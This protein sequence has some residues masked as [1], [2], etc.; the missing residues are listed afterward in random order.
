MQQ[1]PLWHSISWWTLSTLVIISLA[2]IL[3]LWQLGTLPPS[4]YWEEVA[5]GYDAYSVLKTGRDHHGAS[6]PLIAFES[7]G[8]WKPSGYFYALLPSLAIFDLT[9][10][11]VRLPSALAGIGI[12]LLFP[13]LVEMVLRRNLQQPEKL[14]A[15]GL[16]AVSPWLLVF[17]RG[18]WE[19]N[20]ATFLV[21]AGIL[22]WYR[23][24]TTKK[25]TFTTFGWAGLAVVLLTTSMY[26]YHA[27]RIIAPLWALGSTYWAWATWSPKSWQ[28]YL[29]LGI[30]SALVGLVL[31]SPIISN[32]NDK[33][34]TQ[35]FQE[36]SIFADQNPVLMSN[37]LRAEHGNAWW[38]RL[39][40]HR[41]WFIAKTIATKLAEHLTVDFLFVSGDANARHRSALYGQLLY[42]DLLLLLLGIYYLAKQK[43]SP[44]WLLG[45][46]WLAAT[47]PAA[48]TTA[49]PHALRTLPAA[50][51][52]LSL[53]TTG[54]FYVL[55][56][57]G[58]IKN[59]LITSISPLVVVALVLVY[60]GF[61][62]AWLHTYSK[63]Y[64][65][66]FA[67]DWQFGYQQMIETVTALSKNN[68]DLPITISR[69]QG[70]PAMYWWFY[71][72][73]DP[74][75]VQSLA[76][77]TPKDQ[78]EFLV[79]NN[80]QFTTT[81]ADFKPD[82]IV[83]LSEKE[84]QQLSDMRPDWTLHDTSLIRLPTHQTVWLIGILRHQ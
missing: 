23:A 79:F 39:V 83:A 71:T 8:D 84:W 62:F 80:I 29:G 66:L 51:V 78:G 9:V 18:A 59:K 6:W 75:A 15:Y 1:R 11:S 22:S 60:A 69:Q 63:I 20:L 82:T 53:A 65:V 70:R 47:I 55:S 77:I 58:T 34:V 64:P 38:A 21:L 35:R 54:G 24:L 52:W 72:K 4:P 28:K 68:P 76:P 31:L 25:V 44:I 74:I 43:N 32:L 57:L 67:Q 27:M 50:L 5:L 45:W 26:T 48:L 7:F 81:V 30:T 10:W 42:P 13:Y 40:Y 61:S 37:Q 36:T 2:V 3:R 56:L 14:I 49:T 73:T 41:Y 19:V 17:S 33:T 12:V 46:L 16:A